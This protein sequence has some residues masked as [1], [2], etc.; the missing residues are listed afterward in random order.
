M[1]L[2]YNIHNKNIYVAKNENNS[3]NITKD[4]NLKMKC[5]YSN[6][7]S[8]NNK[9]FLQLNYIV[10]VLILPSSHRL[11]GIS[12]LLRKRG[13]STFYKNREVSNSGSV[14]IYNNTVKAVEMDNCL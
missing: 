3:K 9:L 8:L 5:Y 14:F 11:G 2:E 6:V 4:V 7:T 13:Y 1:S 10:R 12:L